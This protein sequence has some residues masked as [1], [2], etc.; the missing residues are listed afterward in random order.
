MSDEHWLWRLSAADWLQ[1][2]EQE[3]ASGRGRIDARRTAVTHAR[4][5]AGMALN[6][7]LVASAGRLERDA[8][9]T[10]WGRSYL[11][12]LR[13][14][15]DASVDV[16]APLPVAIGPL[17]RELVQIAPTP[18]ERVIPLSRAPH[19]PAS[20]AL[21]LASEVVALC[22]AVIEEEPP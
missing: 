17:A 1:A 21:E 18:R 19:G 10:R 2:A 9:E 12:H 15:T 22:R 20:R 3:L 6:G 14:L 8:C 7:V 4:R 11:E 13:A 16:C 5:A